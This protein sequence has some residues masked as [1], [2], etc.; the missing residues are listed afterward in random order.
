M[1][2]SNHEKEAHAM[3]QVSFRNL[4]K[5]YG[6]VEILHGL[7]LEVGEGEFLVLLG[8]SGCG[9]STCLRML[10]GLETVTSGTI[11]IDGRDVTAL[12]PHERDIAMV[13]QNYALYPTMTVAQNIGFG[14]KAKKTPPDE[15][16]RKVRE[17]A[18]IL[19]LG[20]LLGRKP[21][22]LSGGQQ[23][24]VAI[25]RAIVRNPKVFLFDEPLSNLDANL[26]VE[27]RAE[28]MRLHRELGATT[29]FVT[30]DQEEAMAMA[31]RIVILNAGKIEQVGAPEDIY[32][33]PATRM[34]AQFIG[35]PS[36]NFILGTVCSDGQVKMAIGSVATDTSL[37]AGQP[38]EI[39]VRPEQIVPAKRK[40]DAP[41]LVVTSFVTHVELLG[42]RATIKLE[43]ESGQS[44]T[45]VIDH[46]EMGN[47]K[48][49][50]RVEI[51][52]LSDALHIFPKLPD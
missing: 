13:F 30:H 35:N 20:H 21:N 14:L 37:T 16:K 17:T 40:G 26:R 45:S 31:D 25:G 34:V 49:G 43:H 46:E 32:F 24:R 42:P 41:G 50:A 6:S 28:I 52:M 1:S 33:R 3:G 23:Q 27:M 15:I 7:D 36:M 8:P 29:V 9:K 18:D 10:A 4:R 2:E 47:F 12:E 19:D 38:V 11:C 48:I 5:S 22:A 44:L 51:A 39:A